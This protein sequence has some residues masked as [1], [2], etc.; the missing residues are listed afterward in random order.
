MVTSGGSRSAEIRIIDVG[1]ACYTDDSPL[2][3]S[4]MCG[5]QWK[6]LVSPAWSAP[7]YSSINWYKSTPENFKKYDVYAAGLIIAHMLS[8]E[9]VYNKL[10]TKT[11]DFHNGFLAHVVHVTRDDL[12]NKL[13]LDPN[14]Y[15]VDMLEQML[16]N[17]VED[18][19]D[20]AEAI[21]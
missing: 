14:I 18:R 16:K 5:T 3:P 2:P 19:A 17:D 10:T 4:Q 8:K 6:H 7:E 1:G 9:K 21:R 11:D 15:P 20:I 13:D 12:V